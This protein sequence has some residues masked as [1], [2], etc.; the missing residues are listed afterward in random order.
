M[1][2]LR[3]KPGDDID[4]PVRR[5]DCGAGKF[6]RYARAGA[7]LIIGNG[8]EVIGA[9]EESAQLQVK[10]RL[11]L[12]QPPQLVLYAAMPLDDLAVRSTITACAA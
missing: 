4:K 12:R 10:T 6:G 9:A 8:L 11:V 1:G 7:G 2:Q 3:Q 5:L